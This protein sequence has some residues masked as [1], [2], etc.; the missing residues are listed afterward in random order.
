MNAPR[1]D[2]ETP[3]RLRR[4]ELLRRS[5]VYLVTEEAF[6]AGRSSQEI[7]EACLR[8][9]VRVIQVR[10]KESGTRRAFE[11][12]LDIRALT[13]RYGALLIVNDRVDVAMACG[14]D[15]VHLGQLD[16][17]LET[18]RRLMG[19]DALIGLSITDVAQLTSP[20]VQ[21]ADYL[22]V[23]AVFPTGTKAD[24]ALPGL[25]LLGEA[26]AA[27]PAP[28]VA[29]GGIRPEN[30]AL[31]IVAGADS[32]AVITAITEAPDPER[33]VG[34]LVASA[35]AA[36][37][38]SSDPGPIAGGAASGGAASGGDAV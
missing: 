11:I 8:A 15:G 27:T 4:R 2:R 6:S 36:R 18:A 5:P 30:A 9:G 33:A 13:S 32:L 19:P 25:A 22:G 12:A 7:A 35:E 31:P 23:G 37:A 1:D 20:D 26:R 38:S 28:I 21:T 3:E 17:P 34:E 29:I 24:A 14:A 16:L 10:E